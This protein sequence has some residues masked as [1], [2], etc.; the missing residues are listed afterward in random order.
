MN[1]FDE[2]TRPQ[3]QAANPDISSWVSANA[4]SGKTKVLTDRVARL[5]LEGT[6]PSNILCLTFTKAA[7]ANMQVRLF[8]KLGKWSLLP[9]I[10]LREVLYD[11]GETKETLTAQKI[12]RARTLF[13][14][15]LETP[16]GLKIQT[17]HAFSSALLRKFPREAGISPQ[18][19]EIDERGAKRLQNAVLETVATEHR[20]IFDEIAELAKGGVP[21]VVNEVLEHRKLFGEIDS[22]AAVWAAFGLPE[23]YEDL[24]LARELFTTP[25]VEMLSSLRLAVANTPSKVNDNVLKFLDDAN[26]DSPNLDDVHLAEGT[27]LT[28]KGEVRKTIVT[29]PA[30]KKLNDIEQTLLDAWT[31]KLARIREIRLKAECAQ[32]S[33]KLLRFAKSFLAAYESVKN[34]ESCLDF[35][36]LI[37]KALALLTKRDSCDWVMYKLDAQIDHILVDEAQDVNPAQ[38]DI[39]ARLA[40]EFTAGSGARGPLERTVF[41][42]GDEKQSIFGFQGARPEKFAQMHEHFKNAHDSAARTFQR[43]ELQYSFRSA[44]SILDL[45]DSVFSTLNISE[46]ATTISH[47]SFK[48][49]LPGRVDLWPFIEAS[50]ETEENVWHSPKN[51]AAPENLDTRLAKAVAK[52][53]AESVRN[54]VLLPADGGARPVRPGDFLI[55][56]QSR[57]DIFHAIIREL[58]KNGLPIAGTDRLK[59]A[60][61]LAV[62]DLTA[63]LAFL[64]TPADDYSLACVLRSPLFGLTESQ[65][66]SLAHSREDKSLW[67]ALVEQRNVHS[68]AVEM[69][70]DLLSIAETAKPY[71]LL[72][73]VLT[74]Y[75]GRERIISR[76]GAEVEEAIDAFLLQSLGYERSEPSSLTGFLEWLAADEMDVKRELDQSGDEIRVMTV[77]GAKG[78]ESPIVILPQ[79]EKR[80]I[81]INNKILV[82]PGGIPVWKPAS[83]NMPDFVSQLVKLYAERERLER[84]RLLYVALTRAENWLV[85]CGAGTKDEES[86]YELVRGGIIE[87]G[88]ATHRFN[89]LDKTFGGKAQGYRFSNGSWPSLE[90]DSLK[91]SR[92][93]GEIALPGWTQCPA[94]VPQMPE[95]PLPPSGLGGEKSIAYDP[96]PDDRAGGNEGALRRGSFIHLLLEHLPAVAKCERLDAA[97]DLRM[98]IE[99]DLSDDEFEECLESCDLMLDDPELQFLFSGNALAEVAITARPPSLEQRPIYGFID[100]LLVE[101]E[102][103]L[104]V[105]FKTNAVVPKRSEDVPEAILRQMG[106]YLESLELIYP[107]R[108]AETAILWTK[109]SKLMPLGREAVV[110]ALRRAADE[111]ANCSDSNLR[112]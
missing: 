6:P 101:P 22:E 53:V 86:W 26:L 50:G 54:K 105:D 110:S 47:R 32:H 88:P 67:A 11:L 70:E 87:T 41:A 52:F 96:S 43:Q 17:I 111:N 7:A 2:A 18:F 38:W 76:M 5:L 55:L 81:S 63:I 112:K 23:S 30:L 12:Q 58:K 59:V 40:E 36:D 51:R 56:V 33:I 39:V 90:A 95:G 108:R 102:R 98:R 61:E 46:S 48:Q 89:E 62:K 49:D 1:R 3:V 78:L 84:R 75:E 45:V 14:Q 106:A 27:F 68:E 57:S 69:L 83:Q 91:E 97:K 16:G 65:L 99:E 85:A 29:K 72:E 35:D 94:S 42:V 109:N 66:F 104:A 71:E 13:A 19:K 10:E 93:N 73:A 28:Q 107:G 25:E 8:E 74:D 4:G 64:A 79:T 100:L 9:E 24:D 92:K 20:E 44:S 15:A 21:E 34:R 103:V 37:L 31:G 77:H 60:E 80:R 82:A